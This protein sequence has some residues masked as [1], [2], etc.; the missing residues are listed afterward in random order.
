RLAGS[1]EGGQLGGR[2][3]RDVAVVVVII[4]EVGDPEPQQDHQ[5]N[6]AENRRGDA[7]VVGQ[8][9]FAVVVVE[10]ATPGRS[11]GVARRGRIAAGAARSAVWVVLDASSRD[12]DVLMTSS[13]RRWLLVVKGFLEIARASVA[14]EVIGRLQVVMMRSIQFRFATPAH[15]G[16]RRAFVVSA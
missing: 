4:E 5:H 2:A 9:A 12:P 3:A 6:Y 15:T 1:G 10:I 13:I 14:C 16:N 11:A 7:R 8:R